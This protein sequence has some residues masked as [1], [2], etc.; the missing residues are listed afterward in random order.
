MNAMRLT[1]PLTIL[2]ALFTILCL[3]F[4]SKTPYRQSGR[5]VH[6]A[7]DAVDIGAP[8]ERQHANYVQSLLDGDGFPVLQ[9][10][11]P[12]L[13]ETYQAHQ[14]P[15]Y[16]VLAAGFCKLTGAEPSD[17]PSG[18]RLRL[19]NTIIGLGTLVALFMA[20]RWGLKSDAIG[21]AA[22]AFAGL[23]PMFIALHSAVSNDPLLFLICSWTVA[24][25]ARGIRQGWDW[26]LAAWCGVVVGLGLLTK[27]TAL[28]LLPT[29]AVALL[30]TRL[31][32]EGRPPVRVWLL[33]L[34]LPVVIASP[35]MARNQDLY[36]DP[37]AIS[38]FNEAF[39]GSPKPQTV[40]LP[41]RL[42][43][44]PVYREVATR[45]IDE[46]G[47]DGIQAQVL[48]DRVYDEV[49]FTP[50]VHLD[51]WANWVGWWTARSFVGVFGYMDIFL[52]EPSEPTPGKNPMGA[53]NNLY[54]VV[55][56]ALALVCLGWL[57]SL[58][59]KM[60][61]ATKALTITCAVLLG[62]V[63]L[64]F[65]RFNLQYFQGQARYLYPAIA[66]ISLGLAGGLCFWLKGREKY[67]WVF[68][69]AALLILDFLAYKAIS[70]GFPVRIG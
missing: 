70:T 41:M 43:T 64:L 62:V 59:R 12:D 37:F 1:S 69:A 42:I 6:Q 35:W 57:L 45:I 63:A 28:A 4:S 34:V 30:C 16:Y 38:A 56:A 19:L 54:R 44:D 3:V 15:L 24:L 58:R 22:V 68:V 47:E 17:R 11:S 67:A 50:A 65:V 10:G 20:A 33:A 40:A 61:G 51:Y 25:A 5:L 9:P 2:L 55:M 29:V 60:D 52:L 32:G 31:W 46:A 26:K 13:G 18:G 39:V 36:G 21:L 7:G 8:D 14:P 49:G 48:M 27:T 66:P 23:M 53:S